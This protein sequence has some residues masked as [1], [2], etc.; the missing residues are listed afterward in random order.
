MPPYAFGADTLFALP[1]H[2]QEA[3][4]NEPST[5][6][7]SPA[8]TAGDLRDG[9]NG[10]DTGAAV[11]KDNTPTAK[12]TGEAGGENADSGSAGD[13]GVPE[14]SVPDDDG[15]SPTFEIHYDANGNVSFGADAGVG[16][17]VS[18]TYST[19]N[20]TLDANM[21]E[22]GTFAV[23]VHQDV[24]SE[25]NLAD[26]LEKILFSEKAKSKE[27]TDAFKALGAVPIT[28][29]IESGNLLFVTE[30]LFMDSTQDKFWAR[31]KTFGPE[32]RDFAN[33]HR[34]RSFAV[35]F[36]G[37]VGS[38]GKIQCAGDNPTGRLGGYSIYWNYRLGMDEEMT[39]FP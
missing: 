37:P 25:L 9:G 31:D 26:R 38:Y 29:Q 2:C 19:V 34:P 4:W 11:P 39:L 16:V 28:E 1:Q 35:P 20:E 14:A 5:Q 10:E 30:S 3:L 21:P 6:E 23:F 17:T 12:P 7:S 18:E 32:L 15:K 36:Y 8:H 27:C 22:N 33:S 13:G 24:K